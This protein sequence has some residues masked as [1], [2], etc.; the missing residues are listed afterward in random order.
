MDKWYI[1]M[2]EKAIRQKVVDTAVSL[3][4]IKEG[5]AE[6]KELVSIYNSQVK[7]PRGYQLR[8]KD[9]WCAAT[10]SVIGIMLR[11]SDTILP[12]V[13]CGPMIELYK[14]RGRW[15]ERDDYVPAPGD[16]IMYDWDAEKGECL[17]APDHVGM[18]E[19]VEG[20]T[21]TVIE[22]NYDDQVKRRTI[23][24]EYVKTRGFCLPD[25]SALVQPFSDVDPGAWY[26][27][28][29]AWGAEHGIVEGVGDGLFEP[30]RPAT[31]AEIVAMLRRYDDLK[32][33]LD[34]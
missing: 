31:R 17:G 2:A 11:I 23:C 26:A 32:N 25:Y 15:M 21:I 30:D 28:D 22:G 16:I 1:G 12:E 24:V 3:L 33:Q 7:L 18:V 5:T 27:E 34:K 19:K 10:I 6:H 4:G 14:A 13:G 9:P 8:E 20:N 29:V